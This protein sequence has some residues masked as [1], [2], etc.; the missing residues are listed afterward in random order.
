MHGLA[1]DP[2]RIRPPGPAKYGVGADVDAVFAGY[3]PHAVISDAQP[4]ADL[5]RRHAA[6][7]ELADEIPAARR[8]LWR[9]VPRIRY[10]FACSGG[11]GAPL[12]DLAHDV[13]PGQVSFGLGLA[14]SVLEVGVRDTVG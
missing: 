14:E 9:P 11:A 7:G 4:L 2:G 1:H 8:C 6:G 3:L 12:A 5:L 10:P 13:G